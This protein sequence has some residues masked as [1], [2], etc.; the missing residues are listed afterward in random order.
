MISGM[1]QHRAPSR[2]ELRSQN[3]RFTGGW[4]PLELRAEFERQFRA[5][6]LSLTDALRDAI[7]SWVVDDDR[8]SSHQELLV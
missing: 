8:T 2:H 1:S 3:A 5:R 7:A 6:G 4:V